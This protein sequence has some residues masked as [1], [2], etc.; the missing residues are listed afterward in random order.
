M[1]QLSRH[2]TFKDFYLNEI[3]IDHKFISYNRFVE[4]IPTALMPLFVLILSVRGKETGKY[5]VDSTK[6]IVC[7]NLRINRH[8]VFKDFAQRGKAST[9]WFFGF[10]LHI[11]INGDYE[12]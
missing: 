9:G 8:K 6:L 10:K 1:F 7:D 3:I 4:L 12:L 2:K 5:Y 11:I